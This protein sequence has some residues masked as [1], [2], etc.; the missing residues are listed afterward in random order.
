MSSVWLKKCL[1]DFYSVD[2]IKIVNFLMFSNFRPIDIQTWIDR[3]ATPPYFGIKARNRWSDG[4]GES[5][6]ADWYDKDTP[7]LGSEYQRFFPQLDLIDIGIVVRIPHTRVQLFRRSGT[8]RNIETQLWI[9]LIVVHIHNMRQ[10][11]SWKIEC[12][13]VCCGRDWFGSL[14]LLAWLVNN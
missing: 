10:S 12:R 1:T 5:V 8:L 3:S 4:G 13:S 14:L 9:V 11:Q 7:E 6:I 2:S